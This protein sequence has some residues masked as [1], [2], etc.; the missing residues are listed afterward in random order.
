MIGVVLCL[1][2]AGCASKQDIEKGINEVSYI[3]EQISQQ[4]KQSPNEIQ[5]LSGLDSNQLKVITSSLD[6]YSKQLQKLL[7]LREIKNFFEPHIDKLLSLETA[8]VKI[9]NIYI[10]SFPSPL[11]IF[12]VKL[13]QVDQTKLE[14][15]ISEISKS[16]SK[17][18]ILDLLRALVKMVAQVRSQRIGSFKVDT[19]QLR[20]SLAP[21]S[22]STR[23][24][25]TQDTK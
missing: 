9:E 23:V 1:F 8:G 18:F 17:S 11:L 7:P 4:S 10:D 2:L 20:L 24:K 5:V 25:F 12:E 6:E 13:E 15:L 16:E 14:K 3:T 21:P 22:A 19:L